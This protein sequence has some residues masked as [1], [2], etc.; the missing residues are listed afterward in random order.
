MNSHEIVNALLSE[1]LTVKD[2]M[3]KGRWKALAA[4][5]LMGAASLHPSA[6]QYARQGTEFIKRGAQT[7]QKAMEPRHIDVADPNEPL[8]S[9]KDLSPW[10]YVEKK[11]GER[12]DVKNKTAGFTQWMNRQ[13]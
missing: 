6:G 3:E 10:D 9:E 13:S 12:E 8:A 4:A 1:D 2:L 7:V 11:A 5:G